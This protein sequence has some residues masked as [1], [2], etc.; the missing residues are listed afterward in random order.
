M[1]I[2]DCPFSIIIDSM[3]VDP[4]WSSNIDLMAKNVQQNIDCIENLVDQ[5]RRLRGKLLFN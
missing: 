1:N 3:A 2:K 5:A 4:N